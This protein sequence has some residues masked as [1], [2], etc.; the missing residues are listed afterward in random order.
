[1]L[2]GMHGRTGPLSQL[3]RGHEELVLGLLRKHGPLSRS[4]LA[5]QSG[6]SRTTLHDI[7]AVLTASG[8]VVTVVRDDAPRGR[9]RPAEM[10][11][12]NPDA[13]QVI[14]IDFA[15]RAVH[16]AIV[17]VAHDVVGSTTVPHGAG[18]TWE[19]RVELAE[20]AVG[21]LV[22]GTLRL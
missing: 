21:D 22:E 15:R 6:L 8:A 12:L 7:L 20:R 1:M 5:A 9:G 19:D 17:N 11:T 13:G 16:V 3:R 18:L 14:G 10:L 4:A 2:A